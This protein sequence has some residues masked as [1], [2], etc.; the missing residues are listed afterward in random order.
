MKTTE[1]RARSNSAIVA[2]SSG[3]RSPRGVTARSTGLGGAGHPAA[4]RWRQGFGEAVAHA[5]RR[6]DMNNLS[7][8]FTGTSSSSPS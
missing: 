7:H 2:F 4:D 8:S 1:P 5:L 6:P 3:R